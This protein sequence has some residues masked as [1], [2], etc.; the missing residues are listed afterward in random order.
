MKYSEL[1]KLI[2]EEIKNTM[3]NTSQLSDVNENQSLTPEGI[4]DEI[5][6][7]KKTNEYLKELSGEIKKIAD[8]TDGKKQEEALSN[9]FLTKTKDERILSKMKVAVRGWILR[10]KVEKKYPDVMPKTFK[11]QNFIE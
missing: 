8:S 10:S 11:L 3:S 9:L 5:N 1:R 7:L 4:K 6:I 2:Q